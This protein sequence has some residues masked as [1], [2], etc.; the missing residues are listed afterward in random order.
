M[1]S[2]LRSPNSQQITL[3]KLTKG[4][5]RDECCSNAKLF[6]FPMFWLIPNTLIEEC[7]KVAAFAPVFASHSYE[8]QR[9]FA[10]S[11]WHET[12]CCH[13][14]TSKSSWCRRLPTRP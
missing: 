7:R 1:D 2:R 11:P 6:I 3:L 8:K 5:F 13:L 4:R 9:Q 12:R 14:P 10:S